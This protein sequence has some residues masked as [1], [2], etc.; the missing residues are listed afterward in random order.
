[1]HDLVSF[2]YQITPASEIHLSAVTSIALYGKGVFTT[3]A[4]SDLKPFLWEK[5]W[6]RL[7][8]NAKETG[9][10]IS[11]FD[12]EEVKSELRRLLVRNDTRDGR[13]RITFFDESDSKIWNY[14][15]RTKTSLLI[16]TSKLGVLS[17]RFSLTVSD[18]RVNSTSP[19][20][21]IKS[22]NYLDNLY[23]FEDA[24]AK[25]FDEAV[26]LNECDEVVSACMANIFWVKDGKLFTPALETGCLSGTTREWVLENHEVHQ[27]VASLDKLNESDE[28]FLSSA[29]IGLRASGI[30]ET[31]TIPKEMPV[32]SKLKKT[33]DLDLS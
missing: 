8:R 27:T 16:Q 1:M 32:Y 33:L 19:L 6:K 29:G 21:G 18:F 5:H 11:Q 4:I 23:A 14:G 2:N 26:R 12:E 9:I 13:S 31:T 3:V 25:G 30:I 15:S 7:N 24:K 28:I 22:C 17:E 20:A 10:E